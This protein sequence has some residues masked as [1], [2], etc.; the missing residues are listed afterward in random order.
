MNST[1]INIKQINKKQEQPWRSSDRF[2]KMRDELFLVLELREE[3][4]TFVKVGGG[5]MDFF[6][7]QKKKKMIWPFACKL[8]A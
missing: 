3:K 1:E 4:L 6:Q 5:K 7:K 2:W 8:S